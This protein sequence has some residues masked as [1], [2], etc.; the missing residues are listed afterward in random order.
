MYVLW[1]LSR[2][3]DYC[4]NLAKAF[5]PG[6]SGPKPSHTNLVRTYIMLQYLKKRGFVKLVASKPEGSRERKMYSIT[7]S[8]SNE[9]D[10]YKHELNSSFGDYITYLSE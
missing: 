4:Y 10:F 9:L 2:G 6:E 3:D 7:Q 5:E 8:G 1:R